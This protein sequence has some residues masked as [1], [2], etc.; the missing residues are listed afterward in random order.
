MRSSIIIYCLLLAGCAAEPQII[1]EPFEVKVPVEVPCKLTLPDKPQLTADALDP[2]VSD[3]VWL[4]AAL[5]DRERL[6]Y[7]VLQLETAIKVCQ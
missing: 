5:A 4:K 3:V 7:Y 2:T 1:R 6:I